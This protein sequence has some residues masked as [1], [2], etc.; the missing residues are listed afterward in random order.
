MAAATRG[1]QAVITINLFVMNAINQVCNCPGVVTFSGRN[2]LSKY[3]HNFDTNNFGP[4]VGFAWRAKE[5]RT[6]HGTRR[7]ARR[8]HHSTGAALQVLGLGPVRPGD[9]PA[10]VVL[11]RKATGYN[12]IRF[13]KAARTMRLETWPRYADPKT[14]RQYPGW[15]ITIDQTDNYGRKA[16][17]YLPTLQITGMN[18]AVVQVIEEASGEIVYTLR[19]KGNEFRPKVFAPGKYTIH[20]GDGGAARRKTLRGIEAVAEGGLAKLRVEP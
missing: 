6:H 13:D 12:I 18:D 10:P 1:A 17:A 15:P 20:V 7:R 8:A 9:F 4:R 19:I 5:N 16:A 3:A 11:H 2:G 14:G